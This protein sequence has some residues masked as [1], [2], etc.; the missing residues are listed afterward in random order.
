VG[1]VAVEG[2]KNTG[3]NYSPA[4]DTYVIGYVLLALGS[5][6]IFLSQFHRECDSH[7]LRAPPANPPCRPSQYRTHSPLIRESFWLPSQAPLMLRVSRTS[8]IESCISDLEA[9]L[10]CEIPAKRS[11]TVLTDCA[12]SRTFFWAYTAIPVM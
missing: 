10:A 7:K 5:P 9:S 6:A 2:W 11:Q 12:C 8:S 3:L 1:L 4:I